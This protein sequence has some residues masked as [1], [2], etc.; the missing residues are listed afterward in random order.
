MKPNIARILCGAALVAA[1]ASG[2]VAAQNAAIDTAI[3]LTSPSDVAARR[4]SLIMEVWGT[5]TLP[6]AQ[7]TVTIGVENPIFGGTPNTAR[8]D[9]YHADMSNGQTNEGYFYVAGPISLNRVV[10]L[11]PGHQGTC[12]WNDIPGGY[13]VTALFNLLLTNGYS[14]FAMNMPACGQSWEHDALYADYGEIAMG[15]FIEPI[16][17]A[18]NYMQA[19]YSFA[20]YNITGLSGGGWTSDV[21][22]AIEIRLQL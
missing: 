17:Q 22:P 12:D 8:V 20:N 15:Y 1:V 11:N 16:V 5:K 7:S 3:T 6:T 19:H 13:G 21:A 4:V 18:I 10:F 9:L 2:P 14:V